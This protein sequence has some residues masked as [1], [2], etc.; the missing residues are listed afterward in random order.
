MLI[1]AWLNQDL[2][3]TADLITRDLRRA[4]FWGNA[5][6]RT[7]AIAIAIGTSAVAT[8]SPC[9][10]F[11]TSAGEIDHQFSTDTTENDVLDSAEQFGVRLNSA[12]CSCKRPATPGP[13]SPTAGRCR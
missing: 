8:A 6:Q 9:S 10:G 5:I 3:A 2:R 12:R 13:T 1:A 7:I 11:V 4:G